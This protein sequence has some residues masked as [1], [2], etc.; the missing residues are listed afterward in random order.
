M[1]SEIQPRY[2]AARAVFAELKPAWEA[3]R[4]NMLARPLPPARAARAQ[5][6]VDIARREEAAMAAAPGGLGDGVGDD[7][8]LCAASRVL[9]A[10]ERDSA[11]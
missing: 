2:Q 5:M 4:A 11:R 1:L 9:D 6:A 10:A 8:E 3:V 7:D